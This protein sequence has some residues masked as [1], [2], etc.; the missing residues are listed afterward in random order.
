MGKVRLQIL[1][2]DCPKCKV[3]YANAEEAVRRRPDKAE[4][5]KVSDIQK[6]MEYG[7]LTIPSVVINGKVVSVGKAPSADEFEKWIDENTTSEK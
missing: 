5:E 7:V 4:V 3:A 1:G 6:I 2:T